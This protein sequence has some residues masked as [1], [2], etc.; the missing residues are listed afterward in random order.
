[1]AERKT[2]LSPGAYN[3]RREYNRRYHETWAKRNPE[4]VREYQREWRQRNADKVAEYKRTYWER[5]A[6]EQAA[7]QAALD[8]LDIAADLQEGE[9][10]E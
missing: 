5:K 1:M 10:E 2:Q 8:V 4:K 9:D 6:A 3:A 7:D